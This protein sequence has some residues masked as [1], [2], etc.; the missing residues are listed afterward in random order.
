LSA[1]EQKRLRDT[2]EARQAEI[3][4]RVRARRHPTG[5]DKALVDRIDSFVNLS[6]EAVQRGDYT[7]ADALLERALILARELPIE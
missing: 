7:Q 4:R 3:E 5:S 1:E 6:K 2:I